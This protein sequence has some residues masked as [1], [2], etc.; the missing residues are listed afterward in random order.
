MSRET[1]HGTG[2]SITAISETRIV[3]T[4]VCRIKCYKDRNERNV[5]Q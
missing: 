5:T 2:R 1:R 3:P 4:I